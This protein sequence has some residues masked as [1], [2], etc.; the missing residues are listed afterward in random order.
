MNIQLRKYTP[1]DV[2]SV[3]KIRNDIIDEGLTLHWTQHFSGDYVAADFAEQ[4]EAWCAAIDGESAGFYTV[5]PIA[6]GRCV[7][8]ANA[9]YAVKT[10][11]RR[12]GIGTMLV[13]HSLQTAKNAGFR[14]MEFT[15][16]VATNPSAQIY[17][18]AGF[19]QVGTVKDGFKLDDGSFADLIVFNKML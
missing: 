4:T 8:M 3:T 11:H 5:R 2:P 10:E 15:K 19:E 17:K 18:R 13:E 16:V 12:K 9:L 1:A 14:S 7:H 6:P